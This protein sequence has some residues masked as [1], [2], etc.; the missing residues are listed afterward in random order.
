MWPLVT[1]H[2]PHPKLGSQAFPMNRTLKS[3]SC[4]SLSFAFLAL[5]CAS[6]ESSSE[7]MAASA[8]SDSS[9]KQPLFMDATVGQQEPGDQQVLEEGVQQSSLRDQKTALLVREHLM[10]DWNHE[11]VREVD[12]MLGACMMVR[13]EA[14]TDVG[15]M[16]ERFFMYFEDVDWCYR[17][18]EAGWEVHLLPELQLV[19][20]FRRS[21]TRVSRSLI[22]H[23]R[24][25]FRL[26][27][28]E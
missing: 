5:G 7:S 10:M 25:F 8:A 26:V 18:W 19:H 27:E 1:N 13:T 12:W 6:P 24:S 22:H 21:S 14:I 2:V 15:L 9:S 3:A 23:V 16:D 11:T 4:L 17:M 20:G 28:L